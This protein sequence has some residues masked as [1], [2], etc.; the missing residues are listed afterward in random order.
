LERAGD[1]DVRQD[2][3]YGRALARGTF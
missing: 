2:A 1:F 3:A